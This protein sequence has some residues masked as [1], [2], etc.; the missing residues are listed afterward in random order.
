KPDMAASLRRACEWAKARGVAV[1]A[2]GVETQAQ[3]DVI[4]SWGC[5]TM[6]GFLLAQPFPAPWLMQTHAAV[7]ERARLLLKP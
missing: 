2:K 7:T 3:L 4:R 6:Q 1:C 5:D